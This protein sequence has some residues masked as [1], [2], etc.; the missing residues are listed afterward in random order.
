MIAENNL[1]NYKARAYDPKLGR[2]L[3]IDPVGVVGGMNAYA[4]AGNDP[5]NSFDPSGTANEQPNRCLGCTFESLSLSS[6]GSITEWTECATGSD[7][8]ELVVNG[9]RTLHSGG[10]SGGDFGVG[11]FGG[12]GGIGGGGVRGGH[13]DKP[14]QLL[15]GGHGMRPPVNPKLSACI[16]KAVNDNGLSLAVDAGSL[17]ISLTPASLPAS[18]AGL[19]LAAA[20]MVNGAAHA[21]L[22]SVGVGAVGYHLSAFAPVAEAAGGSVAKVLPGIGAIVSL[23]SA[24]HDFS[25]FD[26]DM[27]AC[28]AKYR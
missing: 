13:G 19:A 18:G 22:P 24:A 5:A 12:D 10:A 9:C 7:A 21:D 14:P 4:Y 20:S 3:Q 2:F 15:N 6:S 11:G 27:N 25:N 26:A 8:V 23:I 17:V 28:Q 16:V 1:Y